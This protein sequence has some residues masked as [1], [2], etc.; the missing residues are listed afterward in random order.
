MTFEAFQESLIAKNQVQVNR[1]CD[2][3][4]WFW[5]ERNLFHN[6]TWWGMSRI[7]SNLKPSQHT[8]AVIF[9]GLFNDI[10]DSYWIGSYTD[11]ALGE[12]DAAKYGGVTEKEF[13]C[14]D[15]NPAWFLI[16]NDW[17]KV[18][19][20]AYDKLKEEGVIA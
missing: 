12:A 13:Y 11:L 15:E 14:D 9:S 5:G 18:C 10:K 2:A 19:K 17:D 16:F 6:R 1:K 8:P 7:P 3:C 4:D 20:Y